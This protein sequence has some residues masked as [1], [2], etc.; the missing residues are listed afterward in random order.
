MRDVF[1]STLVLTG[2]L[3]SCYRTPSRSDNFIAIVDLKTFTVTGR[4]ESGQEPDGM[5]WLQ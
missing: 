4:I 5:A 3:L 2:A 1:V